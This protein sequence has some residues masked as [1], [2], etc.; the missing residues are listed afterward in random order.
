MRKLTSGIICFGLMFALFESAYGAGPSAEDS[1]RARWGGENRDSYEQTRLNERLIRSTEV[2]R[3]LLSSPD[4]G[5]PE[6]LRRDSNCIAV[7]PGVLK[8]AFIG[9]G[10]F[11][12]GVL[13]CRTKNGHW[14]APAFVEMG[15]GSF[16]WQ[17]G[18]Q[19]TDL[20]LFFVGERARNALLTS[21]FTL[22]ADLG[23]S[24]GP[25]GRNAEANLGPGFQGVLSYARSEGIFAGLALK[26]AIINP[27]VAAN[28]S[29]YGRP[30]VTGFIL[31]TIPLDALR[32]EARTF[33]ES[34][35]A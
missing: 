25:V 5:V 29:Y 8:A 32:I 16:G 34:L 9:G 31:D 1:P 10:E 27:D 23:V 26:G 17:I 20:V 3:K 19:S 30:H 2:F 21:K 14:S 15:G 33:V 11:G 24:A 12:K 18:A 22:G 28:S 6:K 7:L 4:A 13:S 35:P